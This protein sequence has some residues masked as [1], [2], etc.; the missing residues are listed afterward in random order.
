MWLDSRLCTFRDAIGFLVFQHDLFFAPLLVVLNV[1]T[2]G[3]LMIISLGST[4]CWIADLLLGFQFG[5]Y[6]QQAHLRQPCH[7]RRYARTW[8]AFDSDLAVSDPTVFVLLWGRGT[9]EAGGLA[10]ASPSSGS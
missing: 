6:G 9:S 8:L 4:T 1:S 2:S 7:C 5:Y 10:G 3:P